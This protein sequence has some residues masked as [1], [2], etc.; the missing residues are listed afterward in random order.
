MSCDYCHD[1]DNAELG[2]CP[3]CMS[4]LAEDARRIDWLDKH[5]DN[6]ERLHASC[7]RD[8][9]RRSPRQLIDELRKDDRRSDSPEAK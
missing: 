5:W 8:G 2:I 4:E 7:V 1:N 3:S 6:I 9:S